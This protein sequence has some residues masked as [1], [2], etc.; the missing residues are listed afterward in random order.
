MV[1]VVNNN[2]T[3]AALG[4][5]GKAPRGLVALKF[6][7]EQVT[8]KVLDIVVQVGRTGSLTPVAHLEPVQV[9]GT[10]VAR[11]SLHNSDEIKRLDVR[12]GDTVIVQKA[13]DIIPDIVEVL[14]KLRTGKE[15]KISNANQMSDMQKHDYP[16]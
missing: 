15:K 12:I 1:V 3:F 5:V 13:G 6:S 4:V 9:A 8:T 11:A 7:A 10:T 16:G 2:A 14:P